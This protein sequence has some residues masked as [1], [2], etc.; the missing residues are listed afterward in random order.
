[1]TS[2]GKPFV[3]KSKYSKFAKRG[4]ALYKK[5]LSCREVGNMLGISYQVVRRWTVNTGIVRPSWLARQGKGNLQ[6]NIDVLKNAIKY[7]QEKKS[8]KS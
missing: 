4:I 3:N 5:G 1:M 2:V 8:G 7:L 6:E